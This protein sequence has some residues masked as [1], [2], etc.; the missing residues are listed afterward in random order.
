MATAVKKNSVSNEAP[1]GP[2]SS[3]GLTFEKVWLMFK[4]QQ[5]DYE[6]RQKDHE[7]WQKDHEMRQKDHEMR[8]K[9]NER[10]QKDHEKRQKDYE[11]RQKDYEMRQKDYDR[12]QEARAREWQELREQM[13]ETD[14]KIGEMSNR[15][16]E[17]AEHLVAPGIA[18][19]FNEL[20]H[21]FDGVVPSGYIIRND[22]GKDIAEVDILLENGDCIMAVEVKTRPRLQDIE[23]HVKRLE[24]LRE[25][26]NKKR[27]NRKIYGAIAGVVYGDAEKD[28]TIEA[29]FYV[30][31]QTGDTMRIHFPPDFIPREW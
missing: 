26:R 7:K 21:H 30:L 29:G 27:D 18:A 12:Q 10:L 20:G 1:N 2:P 16:G 15:F 6:M 23:H 17:L 13:K 9:E 22:K 28:A 24:I 5:K 8:Q 4:E 19:K 31:E 25:H 14:R 3:E 11:K